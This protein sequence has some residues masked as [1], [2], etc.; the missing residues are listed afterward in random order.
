MLMTAD[1]GKYRDGLIGFLGLLYAGRV[2]DDAF[3]KQTGVNYDQIDRQ[4]DSFLAVDCKQ[5][6][7]YLLQPLSI[8][9]LAIPDALP[10]DAAFASIGR[11]RNLIWLD[12]GGATITRDGL[13]RLADCDQMKQLF[14]SRTS[15]RENS[16]AVL[17]E[18]ALLEELDL[19]GSDLSDAT[20]A[21]LPGLKNLNSLSL[22]NTQISDASIPVLSRLPALKSVSLRGTRVSQAGT[23]QLQTARPDVTVR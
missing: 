7:S 2:K 3:E 6:T 5:V 12:L 19:S 17:G 4:Y 11:C 22:A 9:E 21:A 10:D 13:D 18:L 16:L 15:I 14:L 8:T 20:F 1:K 23:R